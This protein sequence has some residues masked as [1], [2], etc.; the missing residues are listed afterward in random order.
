MAKKGNLQGLFVKKESN[1]FFE[2]NDGNRLVS[3]KV[4]VK[5]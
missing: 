2:Y 3:E 1:W 5:F 4:E